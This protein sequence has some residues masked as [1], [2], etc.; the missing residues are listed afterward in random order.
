M[1][2][3]RLSKKDL[4]LREK[5]SV[6]E[7]SYENMESYPWG[8]EITLNEDCCNKLGLDVAD[9]S[10]GDVL[11]L[12]CRATVKSISQNSTEMSVKNRS[13]SLQITDLGLEPEE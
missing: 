9:Y 5:L 11:F 6:P 12:E 1:I 3:M 7:P 8:L 10:V 13:M 4:K 2:S